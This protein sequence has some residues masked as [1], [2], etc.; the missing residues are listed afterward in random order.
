MAFSSACSPF[1]GT[2]NEI[3]TVSGFLEACARIDAALI[4]PE[5]IERLVES[6]VVQHRMCAAMILWD[7]AIVDPGSVPLDHI[8]KLAKP[9]TEDWYVYS[10]GIAAAKELALNPP[11]RDGDPA[12]PHRQP[13]RC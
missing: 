8:A 5:W 1:P 6:R 13:E 12:R 7:R 10:P 9:S 2:G 3:H 4:E 11:L